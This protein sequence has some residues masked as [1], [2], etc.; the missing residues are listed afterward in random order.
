MARILRSLLRLA[1]EFD[2]A[3]VITHQ[4][5]PPPITPRRPIGGGIMAHATD[6]HLELSKESG[7]RVCQV[8]V[9]DQEVSVPFEITDVGLECM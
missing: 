3:V 4:T 8:V 7:K 9:N 6:T 2:V 1:E 5:T